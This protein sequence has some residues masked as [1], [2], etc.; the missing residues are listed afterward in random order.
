[1][2]TEKVELKSQ[3]IDFMYMLLLQLSTGPKQIDIDVP[4]L[5]SYVHS[6]HTTLFLHIFAKILLLLIQ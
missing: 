6:A 4:L 3:Q 5:L 1:M 2:S